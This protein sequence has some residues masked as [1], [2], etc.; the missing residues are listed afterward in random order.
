MGL[1]DQQ[2]DEPNKVKASKCPTCNGNLL[3]CAIEYVDSK[4]QRE[5]ERYEKKYGCLTTFI[6]IREARTQE[7]CFD[8]DKCKN[9]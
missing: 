1:T 4:T 6:T 3:I 8:P 5:F 2:L 7:M 9:L